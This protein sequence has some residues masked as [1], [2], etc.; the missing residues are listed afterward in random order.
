MLQQTDG[1]RGA[2]LLPV[3]VA[4]PLALTIALIKPSLIL[5]MALG[6]LVLVVAFLSPL[7]GLY[8]L[9]FSMIRTMMKVLAPMA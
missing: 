2:Y 6:A 3:L 4:F 5:P 1:L 7:A 8:A 9:V